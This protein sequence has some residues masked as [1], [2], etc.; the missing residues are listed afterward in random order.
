MAKLPIGAK[1][2]AHQ[3]GDFMPFLEAVI[4]YER[5]QIDACT[6]ALDDVKVDIALVP[7][8]PYTW[9][10]FDMPTC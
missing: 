2:L 5:G 8:R 10:P 3:K 1:V 9:T 4:A 7:G 6:D